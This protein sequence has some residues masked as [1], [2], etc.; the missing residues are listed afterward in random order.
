M[1]ARETVGTS[2]TRAVL[3]PRGRVERRRRPPPM[4]SSSSSSGSSS[5]TSVWLARCWT[6]AFTAAARGT[7]TSAPATPA[8]STPQPMATI[9]PSG[10][11]ETNR[12]MR[13]GWRMWPSI[14]WTRI[15]PPSMSRAV[16]GPWSTSATS[17][18]TVPAMV[19]PIIGT[20]A[21]R[22]TRTPIAEHERARRGSAATDH[23]AD[24]R[25]PPR[26]SRWPARTGSARSTR[27]GRSCRPARATARGASR[28]SQA[29]IRSPS[30]RKKYVE[31]STMKKPASDVPDRRADLG[32]LAERAAFAGSAR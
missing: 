27:P 8:T 14:C 30:A 20:N 6:T 22:K 17:T 12:P 2:V 1:S 10:W 23:D 3:L 18:A 21:P 28:T 25:R 29:Q 26:R 4:S 5:P 32:D 13:N 11:T 15:T 24:R 16:T 7:A 19:A 9:T 31:N